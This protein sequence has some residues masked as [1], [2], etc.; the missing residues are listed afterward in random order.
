MRLTT[1]VTSVIAAAICTTSAFGQVKL[2]KLDT[3]HTGVFDDSAS[4]IPAFDPTTNR[5][6]VT[7]ADA[8][9]DVF[10][11]VDP[12]QITKLFTI[13]LTD[14]NSVAVNNG[15]VAIAQAA[16]TKTD[17]GKVLFYDANLNSGDLTTGMVNVG[18][19]PDMLT[20]ANANT[21]LVANEG[22]ANE[23]GEFVAPT[24]NPEGS[25][26][27][28]DISGGV[29]SATVM[30][31]GF[32]D[33]NVGGSKA[34]NPNLDPDTGVRI[35]PNAATVAQDLEPEYIAV[36]ED[37]S[38]AFVT[39]QENN[40]VGVL[41]IATKQFTALQP[42]GVKDHSLADSGFGS[43]TGTGNSSNALDG[44]KTDDAAVIKNE[45][46]FGMFMPDAIASYDVNGTTY[47]LT[48]NEGD[49]RDPEDFGGLGLAGS[50]GDETKIEDVTLAGTFTGDVSD[51]GDLGISAVDGLNGSNEHEKLFSFGS[52]SFSIFDA[53]GNLVFDSGDD[54]EQITANA[55]P[56]QFNA[57]N[58]ESGIDNR[59]DNK[60]PEPEG[61]AI[62]E[63]NGS[64][65]A[66]IGLERIGGVMVYDIT[67]PTSPVFI[68][69]LNNRNF[70]ADPT[71]AAALD[72]GPEG[73]LFIPVADSPTDLPLLVVTNEVSGTTTIYSIPEPT[74]M[75][76]L[77]LGGLVLA[78][79][80]R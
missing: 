20:F 13:G 54:F 52:R 59:S 50:L 38:T 27:I 42:L 57:N 39:L 5:L 43:H 36:S 44:D 48:A 68:E 7:N 64:T 1:I 67:D 51:I 17:P 60:G 55:L 79:R 65:Y 23:N 33:F 12:S 46:V 34:I 78:R 74:T 45:P 28:I 11:I 21:I 69:Y 41:D 40:A 3:F 24:I 9:V 66:F 37:G 19:L 29:G 70:A 31:A 63:Y 58:D 62:G 73:L 49:G 10:D 6:F 14:V 26:S 30:T 47:Y 76:L 80:R 2:R 61:I 75:A 35:H 71:T 25:V 77:G 15:V 18:A 32:T 16:A 8:G 4:E 72:L 56:T 53:N 22:E